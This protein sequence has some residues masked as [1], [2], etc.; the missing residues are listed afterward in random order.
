MPAFLAR[1]ESLEAA[2]L[3]WRSGRG[4]VVQGR[5]ARR[6]V[7]AMKAAIGAAKPKGDFHV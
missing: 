5:S 4:R 1:Q 2:V 3:R 7:T 6:G